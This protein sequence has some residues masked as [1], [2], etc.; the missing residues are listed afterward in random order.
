MCGWDLVLL[1]PVAPVPLI[2][3]T[4]PHHA[5]CCQVN[6][7]WGFSQSYRI[8][9]VRNQ[10]NNKI[11]KKATFIYFCHNPEL[12]TPRYFTWKGCSTF[13]VWLARSRLGE[14]FT[15]HFHNASF[16]ETFNVQ[17]F[18][19][20]RERLEGQTGVGPS[21]LVWFNHLRDHLHHSSLQPKLIVIIYLRVFL[22]KKSTLCFVLG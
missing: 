4:I 6:F 9:T 12:I 2:G 5:R 14:R 3:D 15:A 13:R 18:S 20:L 11:E 1:S 17:S 8:N 16:F 7:L 21:S 19:Q 10:M 22:E